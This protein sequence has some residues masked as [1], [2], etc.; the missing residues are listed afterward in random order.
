MSRHGVV[1]G[2][3]NKVCRYALPLQIVVQTL[4]MYAW[5][6]NPGV[7]QPSRF[8]LVGKPGTIRLLVNWGKIPITLL[9]T[10]S[11]NPWPHIGRE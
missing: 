9:K 8:Q 5:R 4:A 11:Q 7:G 1:R 6:V 2:R 10:E 3:P